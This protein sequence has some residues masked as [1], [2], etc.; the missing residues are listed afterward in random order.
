MHWTA[1]MCRA[2]GESQVQNTGRKKSVTPA[3]WCVED[4]ECDSWFEV[5]K[6]YVQ[7]LH[8]LVFTL[9]PGVNEKLYRC[10]SLLFIGYLID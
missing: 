2:E 7:L 3:G 9:R 4:K 8:A 1:V 6:R 10:Y 5:L